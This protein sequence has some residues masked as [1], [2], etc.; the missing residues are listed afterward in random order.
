MEELKSNVQG[1]LVMHGNV[2]LAS[3]KSCALLEPRLHCE[4][5][6]QTA[7]RFVAPTALMHSRIVS[8]AS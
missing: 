6:T 1:I 8:C 3:K 7:W 2:R 4:V 5:Y